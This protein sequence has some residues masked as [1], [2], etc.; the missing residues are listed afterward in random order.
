[1]I[2]F[3]FFIIFI[4]VKY[5]NIDFD[6]IDFDGALAGMA[7]LGVEPAISA[8]YDSLLRGR[9]VRA[10][11]HGITKSVRPTRGSPQGG[12]LSPLI[13]NLTIHDLLIKFDGLIE[14]TC[15]ADDLI[16]HCVGSNLSLLV[17]EMNQALALVHSWGLDHGLQFNPAKTVA[18][19]FTR[20]TKHSVFPW[21]TLVMG[22]KTL[23]T[24]PP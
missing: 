4:Y 22:V 15:Y 3:I 20:K 18:T 1:M 14:A 23:S 5:I 7:S 13:W 16:L 10:T 19:V 21:P 8:W 2:F 9:L 12:V 17:D 24:R 6:N 11:V